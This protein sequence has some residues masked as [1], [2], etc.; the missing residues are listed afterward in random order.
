VRGGVPNGEKSN[1]ESVVAAAGM[2]EENGWEACGDLPNGGK[3]SVGFP[4][5]A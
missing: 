1:G 2:I 5:A 4:V 3:Y